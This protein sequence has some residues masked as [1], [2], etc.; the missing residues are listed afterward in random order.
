MTDDQIRL[1]V[2]GTRLDQKLLL[3]LACCRRYQLLADFAKEVLRGKYLELDISI[4]PVDVEQFF[5]SKMVWHEELEELTANTKAKLQ[6][7]LMRMLRE[8]EL[9][10]DHGIIQSPIMSQQLADVLRS[11]SVDNFQFYPMPTESE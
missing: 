1:L 2:E 7:V 11:D 4:Q 5:E 6:T 3:W 9:L 10:S 8:A